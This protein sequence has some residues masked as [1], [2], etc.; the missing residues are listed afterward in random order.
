MGYKTATCHLSP[1]RTGNHELQGN[2]STAVVI[3]KKQA[4]KTYQL[5]AVGAESSAVG[6]Y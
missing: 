2:T 3:G 1:K 6:Y 4:E 5:S